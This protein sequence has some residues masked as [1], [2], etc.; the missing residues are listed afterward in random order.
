MYVCMYVC[1][2]I[3]MY[4]C[5]VLFVR[6]DIIQHLSTCVDVCFVFLATYDSSS[7]A[8]VTQLKKSLVSWDSWMYAL[9][10]CLDL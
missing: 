6:M 4:V 2:Y 7:R 3:C 1:T 5:I 8:K 10:D 9:Y